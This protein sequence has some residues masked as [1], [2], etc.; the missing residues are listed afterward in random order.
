MGEGDILE[1]RNIHEDKPFEIIINNGGLFLKMQEN[2][3]RNHY[4]ICNN[5]YYPITKEQLLDLKVGLLTIL[6]II[7]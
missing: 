2:I 7:Q 3:S 5:H 6:D 4:N 1:N